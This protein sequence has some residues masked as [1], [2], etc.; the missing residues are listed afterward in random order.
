[1]RCRVW[2][3]GLVAAILLLPTVAMAEGVAEFTDIQGHWAEKEIA[4][5]H[6]ADIVRGGSD[7]RVRPDDS[8]TRAEFA[9]LLLR[10]EDLDTGGGAAGAGVFEDVPATHWAFNVIAIAKARGIVSGIDT[11]HFGPDLKVTQEQVAT[12]IMRAAGAAQPSKTDSYAGPPP[13]SWA[14]HYV[15]SAY[16]A[17]LLDQ[18]G[19]GG[20]KPQ[21]PATR[22]QT[23]AILAHLLFSAEGKPEYLPSDQELFDT[24]N[25]YMR[26]VGSAMSAGPPYDWSKVT[27]MTTGFLRQSLDLMVQQIGIPAGSQLTVQIVFSDPKVTVKKE[28]VAIVEGVVT[29]S[30]TYTS[31]GVTTPATVQSKNAAQLHLRKTG[32]VWK[33]YLAVPVTG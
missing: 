14:A 19:P 7:G 13:S 18:V 28:H 4:A 27:P 20:F 11:T 29:Y 22:A 9:A 15:Q 12:M 5:L 24:V 3:L 25:Q 17:G 23:I 2:V 1:M 32:G 33:I 21:E 8:V 30:A 26:A 16:Q 10:A 31:P 6:A